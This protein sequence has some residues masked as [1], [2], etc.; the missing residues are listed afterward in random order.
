[1]VDGD[2]RHMAV[3][4]D[5][6]RPVHRRRSLMKLISHEFLLLVGSV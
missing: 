4:G 1:M 2:V 3:D 6:E 5:G